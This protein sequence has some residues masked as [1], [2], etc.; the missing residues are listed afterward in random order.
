MD[1]QA[2]GTFP[3]FQGENNTQAG[4]LKTSKTN[5]LL[6][7]AKAIPTLRSGAA[8]TLADVGVPQVSLGVQEVEGLALLAV[9]SHGVVLALITHSPAGVPRR[10][11]HSHVKVALAGVAIAVALCDKD[12]KQ[13]KSAGG[14]ATLQKRHTSVNQRAGRILHTSPSNSM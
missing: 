10:H 12:R 8:L 5:P 7:D 14:S 6:R 4:S 1:T 3:D 13:S 9:A 11:V 2:P